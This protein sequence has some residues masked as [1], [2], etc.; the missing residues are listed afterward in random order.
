M[1]FTG[2]GLHLIFTLNTPDTCALLVVDN[3]SAPTNAT[4]NGTVAGTRGSTVDSMA[5][6]NNNAGD[7]STQD[8]FFNSLQLT[9][10]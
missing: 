1:A 4:V 2:T 7:N 9:S 10:P 8:L 6:F 3:A 5:L